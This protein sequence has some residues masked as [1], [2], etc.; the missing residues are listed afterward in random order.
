MQHP[1]ALVIFDSVAMAMS[2]SSTGDGAE[3]AIRFFGLLDQLPTTRLLI[4]HVASDDVKEDEK[5][6]P[7]KKPYGS[8][9]KTNSARNLWAVTPWESDYSSGITLHHTKTNVMKR[10]P[11]MDVSVEWRDDPC[12]IP[13]H[14]AKRRP[15][16][17][18]VR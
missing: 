15:P 18:C 10:L 13:A 4:D 6:G 2:G 16:A 17:P 11:P 3:G 1:T 12:D 7:P 9:F 5:K 14:L 8:V